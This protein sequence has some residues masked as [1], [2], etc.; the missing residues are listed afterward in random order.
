MLIASLLVTRS[1]RRKAEKERNEFEALAVAEHSRL[2][3][4]VGN[5]P[6]VV[7]EAHIDPE[8]GERKLNF[9]SNYIERMLGYSVEEWLST[10]GMGTS[11]VVEEDRG[12]VIQ[13]MDA[14]V[15][16]GVERAL[17]FRWRAKDGRP[18][19]VEANIGA[20]SDE[21]G[22]TTG[23]RGVVM[24]ITERKRAEEKLGIREQQLSEAQRLAQVGSWESNP[25]T[26]EVVWSEEMYRIVGLDPTEPAPRFEDQ[27]SL[28]TPESWALLNS[29]VT[30]ALKTGEPYQVEL[31]LVR[32][33]G[34]HIWT[35]ARGE[36]SHEGGTVTIRGTLQDITERK[37]AEEAVRETEA[38]FRQIADT[39]PVM[40]YMADE[41]ANITFA[42]QRWMDFTGSSEEQLHGEGWLEF[43]HED[44][45]QRSIDIYTPAFERRE[46]F[47][48]EYRVRRADGEFRWLYTTG[49]PRFSAN[50]NFLGYIGSDVDITDI[51]A[52]GEAVRESETR[53][54]DI[55]DSA[56]IF[57][58]IADPEIQ[59]TY[60]NKTASDFTGWS[61]EELSGDGWQGPIH[62]DDKQ[63]S[64]E[65]ISAGYA[66]REPFTLDNRIRRADGVYSWVFTTGVPRYASNGE[67]LGYIG[68]AI[69]ITERKQAECILAELGGRLITAQEEERKRI[70]RELHDD[71]NQRIALISIEL[72]QVAQRSANSSVGIPVRLSEIQRK[73]VEISHEI[74]R[75]SYELHPSK[76][77]HLGLVPALRSFCDDLARSRG[78]KIDFQFECIPTLIT[79]DITLCI[80]RIAQEALQNAAKHSGA[81][82][83]EVNLKGTDVALRLMVSDKGNGFLV[84]TEKMTKGLGITSIRERVRLVGGEFTLVSEPGN[85]TVVQATIPITAERSLKPALGKTDHIHVT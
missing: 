83:V 67:F 36:V 4:I 61:M 51:K 23:L 49:V 31:E 45:R 58:W 55:A 1:R 24:D 75:M 65:T 73:V 71:L 72:E 33:D 37:K 46:P 63:R 27:T 54:R 26:G 68:S 11:L 50:G 8:S 5:T 20:I 70:A 66:R 17:Q 30:N 62:D 47:V 56:P 28:H 60:F 13:A 41:N 43:V 85:G 52:A 2:N 82:E 69:D 12:N 6:G 9:V 74:H 59:V 3:E 22:T 80:F 77:D 14:M 16:D 34:R 7:W 25:K 40:I 18:V 15:I 19:W 32:P 57:I 53:F 35:S 38:R 29:T 78:I 44:D 76:L 39:A 48:F 10:P 81:H 64:F 42:N 79:R 21:A 84:S